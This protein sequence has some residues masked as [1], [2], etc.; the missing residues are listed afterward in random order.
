MDMLDI[1]ALPEDARVIVTVGE[2][3]T[4]YETGFTDC[5]FSVHYPDVEIHRNATIK[6]EIV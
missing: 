6:G 2:L 3:R 5:E 4:L 1:Y